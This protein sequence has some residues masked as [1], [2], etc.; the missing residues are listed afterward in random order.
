MNEVFN[1]LKNKKILDATHQTDNIKG[2]IA[3]SVWVGESKARCCHGV[4]G[5]VCDSLSPQSESAPL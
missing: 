5:V 2:V 3:I 1:R 4:C